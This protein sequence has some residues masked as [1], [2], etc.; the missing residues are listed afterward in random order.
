MLIAPLNEPQMYALN[1]LFP[2][3]PDDGFTLHT[4]LKLHGG[5]SQT[6]DV[7]SLDADGEVEVGAL[8]LAVEVVVAMIR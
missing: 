5:T 6:G 3:V 8:H 1:E 2:G 7:V 4:H